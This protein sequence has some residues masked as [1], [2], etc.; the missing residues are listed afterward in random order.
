MRSES[1]KRVYINFENYDI[2]LKLYFEEIQFE[3]HVGKIPQKCFK[4]PQKLA[5]FRDSAVSVAYGKSQQSPVQ[6]SDRLPPPGI[7]GPY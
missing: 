4:T 2:S 5:Q 1:S 6:L 3:K 7:T